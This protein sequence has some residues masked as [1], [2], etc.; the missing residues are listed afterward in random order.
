[1]IRNTPSTF[2]AVCAV[3]LGGFAFL[4]TPTLLRVDMDPSIRAELSF[5]AY[6][7]AAIFL[8][9]AAVLTRLMRKHRR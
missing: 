2:L 5:T 3:W 1:M 6:A 4:V 8:I 7:A 9:G